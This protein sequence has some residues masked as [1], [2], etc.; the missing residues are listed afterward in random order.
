MEALKSRSHT[1]NYFQQS[2]VRGQLEPTDGST[3]DRRFVQCTDVPNELRVRRNYL[4]ILVLRSCALKQPQILLPARTSVLYGNILDLERNELKRGEKASWDR[5]KE[6]R[7]LKERMLRKCERLARTSSPDKPPG[8]MLTLYAPPEFRLRE[9]ERW[10]KYQNQ[11]QSQNENP[12]HGIGHQPA[13]YSCCS[14][15]GPLGVPAAASTPPRTVKQIRRTPS[16]IATRTPIVPPGDSLLSRSSSL[17]S[18]DSRTTNNPRTSSNRV[19]PPSTRP[20]VLTKQVSSS[21]TQTL[22][23]FEPEA[24]YYLAKHGPTQQVSLVKPRSHTGKASAMSVSVPAVIRQ[25]SRSRAREHSPPPKPI[26]Y[27]ARDADKPSQAHPAHASRFEDTPRSAMQSPDPLPIPYRPRAHHAE[28]N[29]NLP[30]HHTPAATAAVHEAARAARGEAP[31]A[32]TPSGG[33]DTPSSTHTPK[34]LPEEITAHAQPVQPAIP[35]PEPYAS[36]STDPKAPAKDQDK[37]KDVNRSPPAPTTGMPLETIHETTSEHEHEDPAARHPL[38]RRRSSLKK[39]GSMHSLASQAKSVTW[40]MDR[41]WAET[42]AKFVRAT[43]DADVAAYELD[44]TRAHYHEEIAMMRIACQDAV[45]AAERLGLRTDEL[46]HEEAALA[47]QQHKLLT[48]SDAIE[49]REAR[50]REAGTRTPSSARAD[51]PLAT[52]SLTILPPC[53]SIPSFL[54]L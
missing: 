18:T 3:G 40:A 39:R 54:D 47:L 24:K 13:G 42:N 4:P 53:F 50:Y 5:I 10:L 34:V 41:D 33:R 32:A 15:C 38:L 8:Q 17:R 46:K 21:S 36:Q 30:S 35:S 1:L 9:M 7:H 29:N 19:V 20:A 52:R 6:I 49:G 14:M 28:P 2:P 12:N 11:S 44:E 31:P 51:L 45:K 27:R 16:V 43:H 26:P 48:I 22:V 25:P 37:E 23:D